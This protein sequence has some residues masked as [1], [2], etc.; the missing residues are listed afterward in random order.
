MK[1]EIF[2]PGIAAARPELRISRAQRC[3][4]AL[5]DR[6]Y[7]IGFKSVKPLQSSLSQR[8]QQGIH[9]RSVCNAL[10]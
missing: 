8:F 2:A 4:K 1:R 7:G 6:A 10:I 9:Y 5:G 3:M